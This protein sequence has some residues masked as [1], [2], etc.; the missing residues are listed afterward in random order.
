[1]TI[2]HDSSLL[3]EGTEAAGCGSQR[4]KYG[5]VV[6]DNGIYYMNSQPKK[7]TF[8]YDKEIRLCIGK[9]KV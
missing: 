6:V 8:E 4:E 3:I 2:T 1:M 7:E 5:K 9:T